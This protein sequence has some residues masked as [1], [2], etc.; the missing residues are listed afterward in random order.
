MYLGYFSTWVP[1]KGF[2]Y[3]LTATQCSSIWRQHTLFTAPLAGVVFTFCI[4]NNTAVSSFCKNMCLLR[5]AALPETLHVPQANPDP[6]LLT[7]PTSVYF[8]RA[9]GAQDEG[10]K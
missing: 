5:Y 10:P 8:L 9:T 4:S 1:K 3:F 6:S 7:C 2:Y